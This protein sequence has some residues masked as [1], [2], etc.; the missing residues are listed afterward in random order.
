MISPTVCIPFLPQL[1]LV[2]HKSIRELSVQSVVVTAVTRGAMA[3]Q[4]DVL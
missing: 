4:C 2:L 1:L 3:A